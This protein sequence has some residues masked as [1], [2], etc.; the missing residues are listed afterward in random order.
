MPSA[1]ARAPRTRAPRRRRQCESAYGAAS[2]G[3]LLGDRRL[4]LRAD[5][6]AAVD[7]GG[8]I[9]RAQL[10]RDAGM[11]AALD[12]RVAKRLLLH[13]IGREIVERRGDAR[14]ELL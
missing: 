5:R 13:R 8:R 3:F 10:A 11:E 2:Q 7:L 1:P 14:I 9:V 12:R 6:I 4:R